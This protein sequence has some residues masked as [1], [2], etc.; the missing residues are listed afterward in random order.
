MRKLL[1]FVV[2]IAVILTTPACKYLAC[3]KAAP[4]APAAQAPMPMP[5]PATP[6]S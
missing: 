2:C 6:A 5:M 3:K 4:A 1:L